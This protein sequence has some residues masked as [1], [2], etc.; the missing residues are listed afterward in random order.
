MMPGDQDLSPLE[1][2]K[3]IA[4]HH[5]RKL[6]QLLP[7]GYCFE[8]T[9]FESY[10][11][12]KEVAGLEGDIVECGIANAAQLCAMKLGAP[13]KKAWG[14]DSFEGIELAGQHDEFQPGIGRVDPNRVIPENRLVSSGVTV[15]RKPEVIKLITHWGF[16]LDEINLIEGWVQHTLVKPENLPEKIAILRLDMDMH[17]ATAIAMEVLWPRLVQGGILII[18]DWGYA[19]VRKA[20]DDYFD[21]IGYRFRDWQTPSHTGWLVKFGPSLPPLEGMHPLISQ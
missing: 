20:V 18:D 2:K 5:T 17:D 9:I 14:Y 3:V 11:L 19:G 6:L 15:H 21:K 8:D 7:H 4:D 16:P 13:H 12:T 1:Y 10:Y